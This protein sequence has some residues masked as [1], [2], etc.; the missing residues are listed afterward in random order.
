MIPASESSFESSTFASVVVSIVL[1]VSEMPSATATAV[2]WA[3]ESDS[4]TAPAVALIEELSCA[5]TP[6]AAPLNCFVVRLLS[7][8]TSASVFE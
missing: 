8:S 3:K 1:I 5:L 7:L 2:L 6:I 4:A